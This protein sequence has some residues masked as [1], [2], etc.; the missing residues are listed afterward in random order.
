[1]LYFD[2]FNASLNV[3]ILSDN[4]FILLI[5]RRES[6]ARDVLALGQLTYERIVKKATNSRCLYHKRRCGNMKPRM[7][8][9]AILITVKLLK[10]PLVNSLIK[11]LAF[12]PG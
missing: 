5:L 1:M 2:L 9:I 4:V 7:T 10:L 8:R 3:S 11:E 12:N 6:L